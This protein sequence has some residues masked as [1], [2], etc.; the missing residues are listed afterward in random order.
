M[1]LDLR[2]V[3]YF[4]AV[5][6]R[7]HFGRAADE[8]HIAQSVLSRQIRALEQDL[9]TL[10]LFRD[11]RSVELTDAG[12]QLLHDA[13]PLLSAA[14]AARHRVNR[15][16]AAGRQLVVGFGWGITVTD[17]VSAFTEAH[18]A[19]CVE[20]RHLGWS[21]QASAVLDGRVDVALVRPPV[22]EAGLR[23]DVLCTESRMV[24]LPTGHRLADRTVVTRA[25]LGGESWLPERRAGGPG[26]R[27]EESAARVG[28]GSVEERLELVARGDGLILVPESAAACYGRPGIAYV[29][30]ADVA[31][32]EI[33]LARTVTDR[34]PAVAAFARIAQA[35]RGDNARVVP[36]D[37]AHTVCGDAALVH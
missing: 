28:P 8:L 16:A 12:R 31:P 26:A 10:L 14:A 17:V 27:P 15:A 35:V 5:A 6:E 36:A 29:R 1:D 34:S 30:V 18:P 2:K 24:A 13:K 11:R 32:D 7:L 23:L 22:E 20:V 33:W 4:V 9:G 19:V 21:E 3:R 37:P 25:D